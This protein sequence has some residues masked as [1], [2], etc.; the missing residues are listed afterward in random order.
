MKHLK[1]KSVSYCPPEVGIMAVDAEGVLCASQHEG[2]TVYDG[3][4]E[5]GWE[6]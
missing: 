5:F 4:Q 1:E 2:Y 3:N 6:E